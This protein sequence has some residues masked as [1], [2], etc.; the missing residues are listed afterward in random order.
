MGKVLQLGGGRPR[1]PTSRKALAGTL[2]SDR[3][4]GAEPTLPPAKIP[5]PPKD[6]KE[7]ER[8]AWVELA[9]LVDPMVIATA[10]DAAAFRKM[11]EIV[12]IRASLIRSYYE[13]GGGVP[14]YVEDTQSGPQLRMR[15][16][17]HA[18]PT[19]D[20]AVLLHFARW[21]L[22]PAD[23]SRVSALADGAGK[24][25]ALKKFGLAARRSGP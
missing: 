24:P 9:A 6:L 11:V 25:N 7:T 18:I 19:Y 23:R 13:E 1:K 2:R 22:D 3:V 12:A 8:K 16:E 14:T 21:G 4:N 5:A 15:P 10:S 20:K 17:V